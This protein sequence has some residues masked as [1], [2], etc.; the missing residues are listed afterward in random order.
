MVSDNEMDNYENKSNVEVVNVEVFVLPHVDKE[1]FDRC[2]ETEREG[3]VHAI[4]HLKVCEV[5]EDI[6][7]GVV[8]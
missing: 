2:H 6:H 1:F 7:L 8:G 3:L 5:S 4:A